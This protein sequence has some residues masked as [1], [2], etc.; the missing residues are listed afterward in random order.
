MLRM[1]KYLQ[2]EGHLI[3][4]VVGSL[5]GHGSVTNG[6]LQTY[7]CEYADKF[8]ANSANETA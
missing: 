7:V 6:M 1:S 2:G 3:I 4:T 5:K 8:G